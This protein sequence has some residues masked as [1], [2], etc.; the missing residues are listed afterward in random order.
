MNSDTHDLI[1]ELD[2]LLTSIEKS[3]KEN[4]PIEISHKASNLGFDITTNLSVRLGILE[5]LA[6]DYRPQKA[7]P[8]IEV[9]EDDCHIKVIALISG[10]KKEDV[11]TSTHDGCIDIRIRKENQVIHKNIPCSFVPSQ[12]V[13]KSLSYNNSVLEIIFSK[14][15]QNGNSV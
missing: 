3:L 15:E 13:V 9:I 10:I 2:R 4:T 8:Q 6:Q 7:E 14:G 11:E 12:I 1:D 5:S